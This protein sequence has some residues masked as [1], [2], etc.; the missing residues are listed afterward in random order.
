MLRDLPHVDALPEDRR[1][2]EWVAAVL[3]AGSR[4]LDRLALRLAHVEAHVRSEP[5]LEFYAEA[6]APEGALYLDGRLVGTVDG[7]NRL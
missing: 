4:V 5:H 7:V 6:G 1:V 2:R 3:R